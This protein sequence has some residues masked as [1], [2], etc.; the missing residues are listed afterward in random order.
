MLLSRRLA[1]GC[2]SLRPSF[3]SFTVVLPFTLLEHRDWGD[4]RTVWQT[5]CGLP[6]TRVTRISRKR[7]SQGTP[8]LERDTSEPLVNMATSTGS[9]TGCTFTSIHYEFESTHTRKLCPCFSH[10]MRVCSPSAATTAASSLRRCTRSHISNALRNVDV[11]FTVSPRQWLVADCRTPDL[12][13]AFILVMLVCVSCNS[14]GTSIRIA[15]GVATRLCQR[16]QL[17][18]SRNQSAL[19]KRKRKRVMLGACLYKPAHLR[20]FRYSV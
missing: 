11:A 12:A 3:P 20:P 7:H 1:D 19:E 13:G 9:Y 2:R 6:V 15:S 10:N 8:S 16:T 18:S 17:F 5:E 4:D 14:D